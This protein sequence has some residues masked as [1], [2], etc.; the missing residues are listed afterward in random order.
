MRKR[1]ANIL[2]C[3]GIF[4][5]LIPL[6]LFL[7]SVYQRNVALRS[8]KAEMATIDS[9]TNKVKKVNSIENDDNN[10]TSENNK[11]LGIIEIPAIDI[12]LPISD[13]AELSD[14]KYAI[15]HYTNTAAIGAQGNCVLAGHRGSRFGEFFKHLDKVKQGDQVII[16]AM[17]GTQYTYIVDY[18]TI[19]EPTDLSVLQNYS[20]D[21]NLTLLTCCYTTKGKKRLIYRCTLKE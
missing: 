14:I 18:F 9:S 19:V 11:Y 20:E 21:S 17:D 2:I 4:I 1:I 7:F 16:T 10:K 12:E 5:M 6:A 3:L 13:G 8:I 15:G